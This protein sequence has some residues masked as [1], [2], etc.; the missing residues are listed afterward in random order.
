MIILKYIQDLTTVFFKWWWAVLTAIA[1]FI[2]LFSF[3][4]NII[5]TK[6]VIAIVFFFFSLLLFLTLS[7]VSRGYRWF[8][9]S[10]NA[11]FVETCLPGIQGQIEETLTISSVHELELGQILTVL[12]TT[13]RGTG[14]FGIVKVDRR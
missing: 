13:N 5:V 14:C 1:T 3:P 2:P 7:V 12:R 6:S 8:I 10:H 11:P 4:D 9:G